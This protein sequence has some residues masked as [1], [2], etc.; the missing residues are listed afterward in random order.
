L[1]LCGIMVSSEGKIGRDFIVMNARNTINGLQLSDL[2]Y[3]L[4]LNPLVAWDH[5]K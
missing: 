3:L 2:Y 5:G 1:I 4:S